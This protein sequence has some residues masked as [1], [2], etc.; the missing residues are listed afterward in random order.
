[1][2]TILFIT[3][4][5]IFLILSFISIYLFKKDPNKHTY[6]LMS[7]SITLFLISIIITLLSLNN[8][9]I[10]DIKNVNQLKPDTV[11]I[12]QIDNCK[13][14]ELNQPNFQ[15]IKAEFDTVYNI[16]LDTKLGMKIANKIYFH[17][18]P[19]VIYIDKSN[20]YHKFKLSQFDVNTII[21]EIHKLKN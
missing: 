20:K 14:C 13:P 9:L 17:T 10:T 7:G 1:M 16:N 11:L 18:A 19:A 8:Q 15:K 3:L 6:S 21:K 5:I 12:T 2:Q 4:S